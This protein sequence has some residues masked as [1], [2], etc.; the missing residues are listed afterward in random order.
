MKKI[1]FYGIAG[2]VIGFVGQLAG[3]DLMVTMMASLVVPPA[4]IVG[5]IVFRAR[6]IEARTREDYWLHRRL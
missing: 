1:A 4:M 3:W 2:S 6:S 5:W